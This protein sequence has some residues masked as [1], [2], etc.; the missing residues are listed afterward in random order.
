MYKIDFIK[1]SI[2]DYKHSE[3]FIDFIMISMLIIFLCMYKLL[4]LEVE[5]FLIKDI[6]NGK[7]IQVGTSEKLYLIFLVVFLHAKGK[8]MKIKDSRY[9][10][11]NNFIP[12]FLCNFH[13]CVLF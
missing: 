7:S 9:K 11:E 5:A 2:L 1:S 13:F 6:S 12:K 10:S 3:E 8:I 4:R